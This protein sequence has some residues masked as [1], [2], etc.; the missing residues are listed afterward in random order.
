MLSDEKSTSDGGARVTPPASDREDRSEP[1]A[2]SPDE[3]VVETVEDDEDRGNA[4]K[5]TAND[6]EDGVLVVEI[7]DEAPDEVIA[8]YEEAHPG[9]FDDDN[10]DNDDDE[11]NGDESNDEEDD[12]SPRPPAKKRRRKGTTSFRTR[13]GQKKSAYKYQR[14]RKK[15]NKGRKAKHAANFDEDLFDFD[16]VDVSH[17]DQR[18]L[19]NLFYLHV[20][21]APPPEEWRGEGGTMSQIVKA[22]KMNKNQRKKV[23]RV[24]AQTH[25]C[26]TVGEVYDSKR[27]FRAGT[28]F[29]K[30]G[31]KEQQLVADYRERGLSLTETT[32][33]VNRWCVANGRETVTR[34]AV[35]T[36]EEK[37]VKEITNIEKRP[38]GKKDIC[39]KWAQCRYRWSGHLLIRFGYHDADPDNLKEGH[40]KLDDMKEDG[41]LPDCFN[42]YELVPLNLRAIAWWDV[43]NY[44]RVLLLCRVFCFF[45]NTS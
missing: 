26:L 33:L 7:H 1:R 9:L 27:A 14:T 28:T 6:E 2:S 36:C 19:I 43:R 8:V 21:R 15:S 13:K 25:H 3:I 10:D 37:M 41:K 45:S 23:L 35:H 4:G 17:A 31:S 24:I 22:M 18:R 30:D 42:P 38:Q 44:L 39:S 12:G 20:L 5:E 40:V 11:E 32:M 29:I 34:S 16:V